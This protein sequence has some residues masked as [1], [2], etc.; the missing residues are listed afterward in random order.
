V[1]IEIG[2][3]LCLIPHP[4]PGNSVQMKSAKS[5]SFWDQAFCMTITG[6]VVPSIMSVNFLVT[7]FVRVYLHGQN[8]V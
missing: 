2:Q 3:N 8:E 6:P 1:Q 5:W 7:L 4:E